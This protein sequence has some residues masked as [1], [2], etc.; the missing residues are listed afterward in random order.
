MLHKLLHPSR[1]FTAFK[2]AVYAALLVNLLLFFREDHGAAQVWG[3]T[4][5][6]PLRLVEVYAQTIDAFAWV[7]LL[8]LFEL[9]TSFLP[10]SS[11]HR[12]ILK[13]TLHGA[14]A[15]FALI[16]LNSVIG[17]VGKLTN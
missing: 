8:L 9:E 15:L 16:I 11:L 13:W 14:R 17:Y 10:D 6:T 12:P 2:Y 1:I 4:S 3:E 7:C 5:A